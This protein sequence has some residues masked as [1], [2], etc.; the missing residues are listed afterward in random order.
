MYQMKKIQK[1]KTTVPS[2]MNENYKEG[3]LLILNF[4]LGK[5]GYI[6]PKISIHK[7]NNSTSKNKRISKKNR[8]KKSKSNIKNS[9]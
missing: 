8:E 5:E 7:K 6:M 2:P 9:K 4:L 1:I 3:Y